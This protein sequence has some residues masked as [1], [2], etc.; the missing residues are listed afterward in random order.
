MECVSAS[1]VKLQCIN[2]DADARCRYESGHIPTLIK[3]YIALLIRVEAIE[4]S[5]IAVY[6]IEDVAHTGGH[7]V[8]DRFIADAAVIVG[9]NYVLPAMLSCCACFKRVR[10]LCKVFARLSIANGE[11]RFETAVKLPKHGIVHSAYNIVTCNSDFNRH[12]AF[13]VG[14]RCSGNSKIAAGLSA[15]HKVNPAVGGLVNKHVSVPAVVC[16]RLCNDLQTSEKHGCCNKKSCKTCY[17]FV[18]HLFSP[19]HDIIRYIIHGFSIVI[20]AL[21]LA[22]VK[23][24]FVRI[25][26]VQFSNDSNILC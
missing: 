22:N 25:M 3:A 18:S 14:H 13:P 15:Y 20:V 7:I 2:S 6:A 12:Q 16:G 23:Q 19:H 17:G 9:M 11:A 4:I 24:E 1:K 26:L 10:K 8:H 21:K 5:L